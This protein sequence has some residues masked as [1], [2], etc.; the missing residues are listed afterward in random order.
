MSPEIIG[1]VALGDPQAALDR[2]ASTIPV[3]TDGSPAAVKVLLDRL[4]AGG[5]TAV[6]LDL[7]RPTLD[8]VFF[9]LTGHPTPD[10]REGGEA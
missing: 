5:V 2:E 10:N 3:A 9:L 4:D 1:L 7:H 6:S 8:D